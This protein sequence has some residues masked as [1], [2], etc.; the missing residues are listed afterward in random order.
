LSKPESRPQLI[1]RSLDSLQVSAAEAGLEKANCSSCAAAFTDARE[2]EPITPANFQQISD[3]DSDPNSGF[4]SADFGQRKR[5]RRTKK[6]KTDWIDKGGKRV[7]SSSK[8][9][10]AK[11]QILNWVSYP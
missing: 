7:P 2:L 11:C 9:I 3:Q 4:E 6:K 1:F 8:T 10:A 5:K